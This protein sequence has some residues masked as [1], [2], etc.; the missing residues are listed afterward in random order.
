[1]KA[2]KISR[3]LATSDNAQ[4]KYEKARK[5]TFAYR[6]IESLKKADEAAKKKVAQKQAAVEKV[7][8]DFQKRGEIADKMEEEA[9]EQAQEEAKVAEEKL[10]EAEK[11]VT[12]DAEL[13]AA[14]KMLSRKKD[15]MN[16][17][18]AQKEA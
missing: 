14:E 3:I 6:Q 8:E 16:G 17:L 10:I 1:M 4:M 11:E 2:E 5:E 7:Q 12:E 18:V 9:H 13:E 15:L